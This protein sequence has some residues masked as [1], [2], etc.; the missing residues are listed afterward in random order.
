MRIEHLARIHAVRLRLDAAIHRGVQQLA[1]LRQRLHRIDIQPLHHRGLRRIRRRHNQVCDA[2]LLCRH[3][4][5]QHARHT[6]HAAIQPQL[7]HSQELAQIAVLQRAIRAQNADGD[8]QIEAG[9]F[10]LQV[11]RREIDGDVGG[12]QR[13]AGVADGRANTI[14]ALAYRSIRQSNGRKALFRHLDAGK[15][16]L[17]IDDVRIDAIHSSTQRLEKH[18]VARL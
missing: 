5:R 6:A 4:N 1:R 2:A 12:R 8:R 9:A 18:P 11:G 16:H 7:A 15:I 3:R 10:L 17:N 14:A 13:K